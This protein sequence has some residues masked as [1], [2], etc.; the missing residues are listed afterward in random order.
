[1]ATKRPLGSDATQLVLRPGSG[2]RRSTSVVAAFDPSSGT[3]KPPHD[4][5]SNTT[6]ER[7]VGFT[8]R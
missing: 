1:M 6:T 3:T 7:L 8:S 4:S 2:G 5:K